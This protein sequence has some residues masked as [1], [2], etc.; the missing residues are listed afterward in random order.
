[1]PRRS[2]VCAVVIFAASLSTPALAQYIGPGPSGG[3]TCRPVLPEAGST[4]ASSGHRLSWPGW[5]VF[6][7]PTSRI[8]F[9]LRSQPSMVRRRSGS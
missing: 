2:V 8:P 3:G 7:S 1:M 6:F 9:T 5:R 4:L